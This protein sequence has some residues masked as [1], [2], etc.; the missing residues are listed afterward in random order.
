MLL[1]HSNQNNE[2]KALEVV[3][4]LLDNPISED[5]LKDAASVI[6]KRHYD[7]VIE[8]RALALH[9]AYP[10][11]DNQL[12]SISKHQYHIS[13][14]ASKVFDI[15]LRKKFCCNECFKASN[16]FAE[17][18]S[19][20]SPLENDERVQIELLPH[21]K[22]SSK[23]PMIGIPVVQPSFSIEEQQHNLRL[24]NEAN[25]TPDYISSR[26]QALQVAEETYLA[27]EFSN[28]DITAASLY[29]LNITDAKDSQGKIT[30]TTTVSEK[31]AENEA[32]KHE[33]S[34]KEQSIR[35]VQMIDVKDA[36]PTPQTVCTQ[37]SAAAVQQT[38]QEWWTDASTCYITNEL[39]E[40]V[41]ETHA[42]SAIEG[43]DV[44]LSRLQYMEMIE[45]TLPAGDHVNI[46]NT[47]RNIVI[48]KLS[49]VLPNILEY[50]G[51]SASDILNEV[52]TLVATFNLC[53][54]NLMMK[55]SHWIIMCIILVKILSRKLNV[56][57][58]ALQSISSRHH[59]NNLLKKLGVST[60]AIDSMIHATIPNVFI[61]SDE[62]VSEITSN[63]SVSVTKT[64][65]SACSY[66]DL[67]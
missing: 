65:N 46:L 56:I 32:H 64:I 45:R 12:N 55:P 39:A 50:T 20:A 49:K 19:D 33:P 34:Y 18:L 8:E 51:L 2:R 36:I 62:Q 61:I 6:Q 28:D 13:L 48:E 44:Q 31:H 29:D 4:R 27:G 14:R 10:L 15:T 52:R 47:R 37:A 54:H 11:C 53:S 7:D 60:L 26:L 22:I 24:G 67:D 16:Y 38:L 25:K 59:L 35:R 5:L 3:E 23:A 42:G 40:A 66:E 43:S 21:S 57:K 1:A 9:C 30:E 58:T 63:D 17:Q 41:E